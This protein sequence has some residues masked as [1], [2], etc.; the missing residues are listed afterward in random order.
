M[1]SHHSICLQGSGRLKAFLDKFSIK[2]QNKLFLP[3]I[4]RYDGAFVNDFW[5]R[6]EMMR[7]ISETPHNCCSNEERNYDSFDLEPV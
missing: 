3:V 4:N 7:E 6:F 2:L 5:A 1:G